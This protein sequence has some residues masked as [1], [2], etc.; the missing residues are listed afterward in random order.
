MPR[1]VGDGPR[2]VTQLVER[3]FPARGELGLK[4]LF[5]SLGAE[6]LRNATLRLVWL[7]IL[8][9]RTRVRR[10]AEIP[11]KRITRLK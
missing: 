3:S 6:A 2:L 7:E 5:Y 8:K 9:H 1:C 4:S 10:D 11:Q